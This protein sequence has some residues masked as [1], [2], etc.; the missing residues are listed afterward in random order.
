[1]ALAQP[2]IMA[3]GSMSVLSTHRSR[4]SRFNQ[5]VLDSHEEGSEWSRHKTTIINAIDQGLVEEIVNPNMVKLGNDP[6][7]SR[8]AF[9]NWLKSTYDD[10]TFQQEFMCVPSDDACSLLT[11]DEVRDAQI[12]LKLKGSLDKGVYFV[13]YDCAESLNGDFA[14]CCVLRADH[15]NNV[16]I[17]EHRYFE[18]GTSITE[19][20][21]EVAKTVRK[22]HA[23]R[24]VS[25]NAGIGRHPTT[26]LCEKLGEHLV[27]AFDPTLHSKGEMCTK[28]KRYFQNEWVRMPEDRHLQDDFLSID[29]M[30][31]PSNN[32]VY[33]ANRSGNIGHGDGFSAFAMALTEVPEKSRSEIKGISPKAA[34]PAEG[35]LRA[36]SHNDIVERNRIADAKPRRTLSY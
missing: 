1:M 15:L 30:I 14:T 7:P 11:F 21:D 35:L 19:Q 33:H 34:D 9:L 18:R 5:I 31:T 20:I 13:G 29:R 22:Y 10:F 36:T 23:R 2:V 12:N 4:N 28:V 16:E 32:V 25:D 27:V 6:W 8:D 24:L 3:G 26:I 17:V